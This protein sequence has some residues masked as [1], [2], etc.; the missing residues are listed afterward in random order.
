MGPG[1]G[2]TIELDI[3]AD[4]LEHAGDDARRCRPVDP[5]GRRHGAN[6]DTFSARRARL[7]E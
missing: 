4:Q 6:L 2:V 5:G 7:D 1:F 3:I